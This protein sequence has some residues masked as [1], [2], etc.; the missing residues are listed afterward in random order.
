LGRTVVETR[1]SES[2]HGV[3]L[4]FSS[5]EE[6]RHFFIGLAGLAIIGFFLLL[7]TWF[8]TRDTWENEHEMSVAGMDTRWR[9]Q[10][11][12]GDLKGA[13]VTCKEIKDLLGRRLKSPT[14]LKARKDAESEIVSLPRRIEEQE[15]AKK[16]LAAK[17]DARKKE[18]EQRAET[19]EAGAE[20]ERRRQEEARLAEENKRREEAASQ[21]AQ[22]TERLSQDPVASFKAFCAKFMQM[23]DK[24]DGSRIYNTYLDRWQVNSF[25]VTS[26]TYE[27][28][29]KAT[30]SLVSPQIGVLAFHA[31][32]L[33]D[34]RAS[35]SN[36]TLKRLTFAF[37]GKKWVYVKGEYY[38]V[39]GKWNDFEDA[40]VADPA[41]AAFFRKLTP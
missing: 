1:M 33:V 24:T 20:S 26:R 41:A 37:Q 6:K 38:S 10:A 11:M 16:D 15:K 7:V 29:V 12:Q 21:R 34:G 32:T 18:A 28:D 40:G 9:E 23:I 22:E 17:E 19:Q 5:P 13:L 39:L 36:E 35:D 14:L 8:F 27:F 31:D 2:A 4:S 25:R 30:Q 3:A